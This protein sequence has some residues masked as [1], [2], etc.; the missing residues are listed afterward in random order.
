MQAI[1]TTHLRTDLTGLLQNLDEPLAITKHGKTVAWLVGPSYNPLEAS[2]EPTPSADTS[3]DT[4]PVTSPSEPFEAM[5]EE[6]EE[7]SDDW[8][9]SMEADFERYLSNMTPDYQALD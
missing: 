2:E 8:D 1:T 6:D 9:L 4:E 3:G 7:E 5:P